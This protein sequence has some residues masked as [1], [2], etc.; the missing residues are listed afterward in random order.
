VPLVTVWTPVVLTEVI[1]VVLS[2]PRWR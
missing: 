2:L 1:M